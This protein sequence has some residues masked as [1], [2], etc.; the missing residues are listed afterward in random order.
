M[1]LAK[2]ERPSFVYSLLR[3]SSDLI[4][5]HVILLRGWRCCQSFFFVSDVSLSRQATARMRQA[6]EEIEHAGS[7]AI[8][9]EA[10]V[11]L[12]HPS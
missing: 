4:A 1:G 8:Q 12:L 5:E 3:A 7:M 9:E 11:T 2:P 10:L 6:E